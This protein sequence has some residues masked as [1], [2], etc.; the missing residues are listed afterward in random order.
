M[1]KSTFINQFMQEKVDNEGEGLSIT[2]KIANYI[3]PKYPI[4][5]HDTP[6]FENDDTVKNV[7]RTI[8]KLEKDLTDSNKHID[9]I[10][11]FNQLKERNFLQ[12][13]M[14]LIQWLIKENKKI[15]FVLNDFQNS[16]KS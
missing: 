5:I 3:H 7:R 15:I 1:G 9:L 13:E 11:Y 14:E 6:G 8:E 4:R 12:L 16:K 2:H 10:L